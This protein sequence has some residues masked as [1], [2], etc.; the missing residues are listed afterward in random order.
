MASKFKLAKVLATRLK[1]Y[2]YGAT[3]TGKTVT[4]LQ[5]PNPAVVDAERGTEQYGK[6]WKFQVLPSSDPDDVDEAIDELINDPGQIKTFVI[7]PFTS[8]YDKLLIKHETRLKLK[9]GKDYTLQPLDYVAIKSDVKRLIQKL[10]SLDMN[11][12]V[13][14][15]SAI[16]YENT[17][18][19]FMKV[20]GT[21][22]DGP[23]G[24]PHMFDV[25]I[26]LKKDEKNPKKFIA[27]VEKDRTNTLPEKF[28]F[29]YQAFVK[30]VGIEGLER[31]AVQFDQKT[32]LG[33]DNTRKTKIK[34]DKKDVMTAGI[35]AKQI[36]QIQQLSEALTKKGKNG[37]EY[38]AE[39]LKRE[40]FCNSILDLKADEAELFIQQVNETG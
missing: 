20:I 32:R 30:Y 10:L 24:L 18:S 38:I 33:M 40:Y 14:A 17:D 23:K 25:V 3:G 37:D 6:Y 29:T 27:H 22:A 39:I 7:D 9:N 1:M 2:I 13:T 28:E 35:S 36:E 15:H 16:L 21:K 19:N 26:E 34:L 11:I 12:I 8:V 4:A 31:E 5:F